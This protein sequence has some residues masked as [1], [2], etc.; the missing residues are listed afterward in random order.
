MTATTAT[1]HRAESSRPA[2]LTATSAPAP[3]ATAA[4]RVKDRLRDALSPRTQR[5]YRDAW[6]R[7]EAYADAAGLVSLPAAPVAVS[8]YLLHLED[9]GQAPASISLALAGINAYHRV[10]AVAAELRG[11]GA[12]AAAAVDGQAGPGASATVRETLRAIRKRAGQAGRTERQAAPLSAEIIAAVT[13]TAATPRAGRTGTLETAAAARWR[14][15]ADVALVRLLYDGLLRAGE[16]AALRW[17]DLDVNGSGEAT[18]TIRR[19]KTDQHAAGA[20]V[21][22]RPLTVAALEALRPA[23]APADAYI[24]T[25]RG[26]RRRD[27]TDG[28]SGQEIGMPAS[29]IGRRVKAACRAAGLGAGFSGHSGRV[30]MAQ[31][32]TVAGA[33]LPEILHAGRWQSARM[34][35]KYARKALAGRSAVARLARAGE[36]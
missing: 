10:Q 30:G 2:S 4:D 14:G 20:D 1:F 11:A 15:L 12:V 32:L 34:A 6:R 3:L 21:W 22:L 18:L 16:V 17:S 25:S 5:A 31:A 13:L 23:D 8:D 29:T 36:V 28:Q 33:E 26:R 9:L 7:W 35:T 27:G 19:S 24:F